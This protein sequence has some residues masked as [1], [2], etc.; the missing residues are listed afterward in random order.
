MQ[1]KPVLN[2]KCTNKVFLWKPDH[3][4]MHLKKKEKLTA[5]V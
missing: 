1:I 4:E 5:L 2:N 3:I